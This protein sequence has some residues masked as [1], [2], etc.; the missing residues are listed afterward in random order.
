VTKEIVKRLADVYEELEG[1]PSAFHNAAEDV[2][3]EDAQVLYWYHPNLEAFLPVIVVE[4]NELV[5][6]VAYELTKRWSPKPN[7]YKEGIERV[8]NVSRLDKPIRCPIAQL[9]DGSDTQRRCG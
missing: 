2:V 6:D 7:C 5:W 8:P 3:G 9:A 1:D 4:E